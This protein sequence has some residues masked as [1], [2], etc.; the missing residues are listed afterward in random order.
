MTEVSADTTSVSDGSLV[1]AVR[2]GSVEAYETL[3]ERHSGAAR[4]LARQL[5]R[6]SAEAEDF[7]SEAFVK[8]LEILR[9]GGGPSEAFRTYTLTVVRNVAYQRYRRDGR[10]SLQ[11][12]FQDLAGMDSRS[13]PGKSVAAS[14]EHTLIA[15]A[16]ATLPERWRTVLWYAEIEGMAHAEIAPLLGLNP[17]GVAALAFRAREGMRQAYLQAHIAGTAS[18]PCRATIDRLGVWT[19]N[20]LSRRESTQVEAHL[21]RCERCRALAAELG[22]LNRRMR[23][24]VTPLVLGSAVAG[25]LVSGGNTSVTSARAAGMLANG[26][27][28]IA[29]LTQQV[30]G[31]AASTATLVV[32]IVHGLTTGVNESPPPPVDAGSPAIVREHLPTGQ[33]PSD[34]LAPVDGLQPGAATHGTEVPQPPS[35]APVPPPQPVVESGVNTPAF[36]TSGEVVPLPLESPSSDQLDDPVTP[37]ATPSTGTTAGVRVELSVP[38]SGSMTGLLPDE[39]ETSEQLDVTLT[40]DLG[41]PGTR[42]TANRPVGPEPAH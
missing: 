20:G 19:R 39:S 3:Y 4:R 35:L 21:D 37:R 32:A 13:D 7:V 15:T 9:K 42:G 24:V 2:A 11:E 6:C 26:G 18:K 14:A 16:F 41:G 8:V 28:S 33:R 12:N 22:D 25:Y 1:A 10:V 40:V 29:S 27:S 17:S 30:A 31:L 34:Q 23:A 36:P 5:T 38:D